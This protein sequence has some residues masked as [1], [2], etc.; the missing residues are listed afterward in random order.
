MQER[1]KRFNVNFGLLKAIYVHLL[2]CYLNSYKLQGATIMIRNSTFCRLIHLCRPS[3]LMELLEHRA[4]QTGE[5]RRELTQTSFFFFQTFTPALGHTQHPIQRI[6][7]TLSPGAKRPWRE[8]DYSPPSSV[9]IKNIL[10][11]NSI[12][13]PPISSRC[14][15]LR[16]YLYLYQFSR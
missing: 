5:K 13:P 16:R 15:K 12:P 4:A 14:A 3:T 1:F 10:S 9:K 6:S 7:G 11:Y 8:A 2:V